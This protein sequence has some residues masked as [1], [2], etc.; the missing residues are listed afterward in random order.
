MNLKHHAKG[1]VRKEEWIVIVPPP[2]PTCHPSFQDLSKEE[3]RAPLNTIRTNQL[4]EGQ[5]VGYALLQAPQVSFRE[6]WALYIV[7]VS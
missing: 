3:Q 5:E 1:D 4:G 2:T 7:D 6:Q